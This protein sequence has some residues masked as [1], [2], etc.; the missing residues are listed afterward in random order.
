[1]NTCA[2]PGLC[3]HDLGTVP[4]HRDRGGPVNPAG[5]PAAGSERY[6]RRKHLWGCASSSFQLGGRGGH[7]GF[8]GRAEGWRGGGG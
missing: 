2:V 5:L 1:M 7:G 4:E 8:G 6:L 3:R